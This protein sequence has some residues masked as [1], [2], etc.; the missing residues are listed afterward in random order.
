MSLSHLTLYIAVAALVGCTA[1]DKYPV[2]G[3]ECGPDDA[4]KTMDAGDCMI[5]TATAGSF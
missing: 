2:T 3:E 1:T 4:V 5:P